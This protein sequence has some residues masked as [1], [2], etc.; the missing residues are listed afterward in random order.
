[1]Y[2]NEDLNHAVKEGIFEQ[3]S[4]DKFRLLMAQEK[5]TKGVD[6]ENFKLLSG[7]NDIFVVIASLLLLISAGWIASGVNDR[8]SA[9][10]TAMLAW[11]L[12]EFFVR[13]RKMSLPAIV[14]LVVFVSSV[15]RIFFNYEFDVSSDNEISFIIASIVSAIATFVHW[16]RFAVPVTVAVG[17]G[18]LVLLMIGLLLKFFPIMQDTNIAI[19]TFL[20]GFITFMVAMYWDMGDTKRVKNDSDVAFWLHLL[21]SPLMIHSIFLGLNVFDR[22]IGSLAMLSI[23][24]V[25]IVLSSISLIIDRRALMVSSLIYVLYA[26]NKLFSTYGFEGYGL[27]IGGVII[28]FGLLF[29]TAYWTQARVWLL[30]YVP[31]SIQ[32]RV[33]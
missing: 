21:A 12:S 22:D 18:T 32:H 26:L 8:F 3:E 14:L 6:E 29:L 2:S 4:V 1:M 20:M 31:Q 15:F 10:V 25:Y 33:P 28:G 7:F 24:L 17:M 19:F 5:N 16:K 27:A 30:Q 13:H 23:V 11:G 9:F